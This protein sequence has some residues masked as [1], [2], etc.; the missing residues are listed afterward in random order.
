MNKIFCIIAFIGAVGILLLGAVGY[1]GAL[2]VNS[3]ADASE[4]MVERTA[5]LPWTAE[6]KAQ[7]EKAGQKA[8]VHFT[9]EACLDCKFQWAL[10][11]EAKL[12]Q[13][14]KEHGVVLYE[15]SLRPGEDNSFILKQ[16]EELKLGGVPAYVFYG[17]D[18]K[19]QVLQSRIWGTSTL[20][21]PMIV[22]QRG[23]N[24]VL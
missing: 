12:A 10:V 13:I 19:P 3:K 7:V 14:A 4:Y 6:A 17:S 21:D 16:M 8:F 11:D 9:G 22:L 20:T 18:S 5:Y 1:I 15:A 23:S 24:T 2:W